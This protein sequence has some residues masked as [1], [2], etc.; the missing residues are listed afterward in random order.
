MN[1][2]LENCGYRNSGNLLDCHC[3]NSIRT[4]GGY[5]NVFLLALVAIIIAVKANERFSSPQEI[6]SEWMIA[7]AFLGGVLNY[8]QHHVL[9]H[10][11]ER[12]LIR[13]WQ[14]LGIGAVIFTIEIAGGVGSGSLSLFA[15]AWH[16]FVDCGAVT[17]SIIVAWLVP[18][19]AGKRHI[20]HKAM[21]AHVWGDLLQSVAVVAGGIFILYTGNLLVDT[22]LSFVIAVVLL[23]WS[24]WLAR[25]TKKTSLDTRT[26]KYQK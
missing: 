12:E 15:D 14:V 4:W 17:I 26:N 2:H 5:A 25:E 13:Y 19:R 23:G 21:S 11:H 8:C 1:Y 10:G 3:E 16:V 9:E 20:T 24:I 22:F 18:Y 7:I 6:I